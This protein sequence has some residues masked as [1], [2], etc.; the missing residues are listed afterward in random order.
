MFPISEGIINAKI[1]GITY[2]FN[3]GKS[4]TILLPAV[5]LFIKPG[6]QMFLVQLAL[7]AAVYNF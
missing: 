5:Y 7:P 2:L 3:D 6:K 1:R 4:Q